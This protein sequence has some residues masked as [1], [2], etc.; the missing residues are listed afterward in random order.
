MQKLLLNAFIWAALSVGLEGAFTPVRAA[1]AEKESRSYW[2]PDYV[3]GGNSDIRPTARGPL[4]KCRVK[5]PCKGMP[6]GTM[7]LS[8]IG[9]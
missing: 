4:S 5:P 6:S 2:L 7:H 1:D 3:R 8:V 9:G